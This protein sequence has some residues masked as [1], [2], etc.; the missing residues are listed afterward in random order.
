MGPLH[1]VVGRYLSGVGCTSSTS[2][3]HYASF[4]TLLGTMH[5]S[6][7]IES[8][9]HRFKLVHC[10]IN[11]SVQVSGCIFDIKILVLS[12]SA[13]GRQNCA[14]MH[15]YEVAVGKFISAFSVFI[16]L[17]V[18]PQVP[19]AILIK[20]VLT[21]EIALL[22]S[23]RLIFAPGIS[24]VGDEF[25]LVDQSSRVIECHF[26]QFNCHTSFPFQ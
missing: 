17:V 10:S 20:S 1:E 26:V 8:M 13:L 2:A 23:G 5:S 25:P 12:G 9:S 16:L 6:P 14:T 22:L 18:N 24:F 15:L 7:P 3:I 4:L 21:D 19:L 11:H